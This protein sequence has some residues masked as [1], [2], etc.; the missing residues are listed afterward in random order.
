MNIRIE[1]DMC[2]YK[3]KEI[4]RKIDCHLFVVVNTYSNVMDT[5]VCITLVC[6]LVIIR[7]I[8]YLTFPNIVSAFLRDAP[9]NQLIQSASD[10]DVTAT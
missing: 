5:A 7:C 3:Y 10:E 8:I 4:T 2:S 1:A 6:L 9:E